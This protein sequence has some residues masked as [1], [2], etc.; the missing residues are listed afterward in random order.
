M[1]VRRKNGA[2]AVTTRRFENRNLIGFFRFLGVIF[3]RQRP[4]SAGRAYFLWKLDG[5]GMFRVNG[6]AR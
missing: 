3:T 5:K 6:R 2:S 4:V 1:S